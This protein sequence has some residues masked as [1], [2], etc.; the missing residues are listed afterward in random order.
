[1]TKVFNYPDFC[2]AVWGRCSVDI[3]RIF[4][5][6]KKSS[7]S[8]I[9]ILLAKFICT[10]QVSVK[11]KKIMESKS[12]NQTVSFFQ[13]S[14]FLNQIFYIWKFKE[15][16]LSSLSIANGIDFLNLSFEIFCQRYM[17]F[18]YLRKPKSAC[19][20]PEETSRHSTSA[21]TISHVVC[22]SADD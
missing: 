2:H 15:R 14:I 3:Q 13:L 20:N 22:V 4:S 7:S 6:S 16:K 9:L 10:L 1:M 11:S 8:I 19:H 21:H 12:V 5:I 17:S 18:R